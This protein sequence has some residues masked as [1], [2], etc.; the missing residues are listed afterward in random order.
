MA[1]EASS[2]QHDGGGVEEGGRRSDGGLE[3]LGEP[4]IAVDPGEEALDH[5]AARQDDEAD[6]IGEFLDDFDGDAGGV[7]DLVASI[8]AI[9]EDALD[10]RKEAARDLQQG[11][12][13]VAILDAG[14]M[15]RE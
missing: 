13:S 14:L 10:E 7:G 11:Y 8:G 3:I 15:W 4:S 2:E 9:G 1:S 6:L 5:P 12:G